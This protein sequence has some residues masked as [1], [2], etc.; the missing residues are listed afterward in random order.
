[1]AIDPVE[2]MIRPCLQA[3]LAF[4]HELTRENMEPYAARHRGIW[5][6]ELFWPRIDLADI[7]ILEIS[8][9]P[10]SF[11]DITEEGDALRV[12][13]LQVR[14]ACQ[15]RGWGARMLQLVEGEARRR[16]L[17]RVRLSVFTDNPARGLYL[18]QG[19]RVTGE[20]LLRTPPASVLL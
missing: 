4:V 11:F 18:R 8:G 5:R 19:Y 14:P 12:N 13:N 15:G 16:G 6:D 3:D 10:V 9:H 17:G 1:M 2:L 20:D 7:T